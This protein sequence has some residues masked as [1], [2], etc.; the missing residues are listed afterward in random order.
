MA[1]S[2]AGAHLA[3]LVL[4]LSIKTAEAADQSLCMSDDELQANV[5]DMWMSGAIHGTDSC[6]PE[7]SDC[8]PAFG[9][10]ASV[11]ARNHVLAMQPFERA[12]GPAGGIEIFF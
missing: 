3:A 4:V 2:Q 7:G 10:V 1:R 6:F 11:L 8:R 9:K 12:Y 5:I